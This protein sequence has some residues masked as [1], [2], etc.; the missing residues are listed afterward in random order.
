[1]K[2][3]GWLSSGRDKA[4]RELLRVVLEGTKSRDLPGEIGFVFLSAERGESKE[5]DLFISLVEESKLPLF[6]FSASKFE[7][8][9]WKGNRLVWRQRYHQEIEKML[10][11]DKVEFSV[12]AGY[13]F[14]VSA[15]FCRKHKLLNLHPALPGGPTGTWQEVIWKLIEQR[16]KEQGAMIHLVTEELDRGTP[17]T[18]F[19]FSLVDEKFKPYWEDLD[20]R[21]RKVSLSELKKTPGEELPLFQKIRE[22]GVKRELPLIYFTIKKFLEGKLAIGTGEPLVEERKASLINLNSEIGRWLDENSDR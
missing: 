5:S 2:K 19:S 11:L 6:T 3:F 1:M 9:L 4:A 16:A 7:P 22:E 17:L 20:F 14:I 21:L 13:M 18:Y 8:K 15:D 10:P 12:L